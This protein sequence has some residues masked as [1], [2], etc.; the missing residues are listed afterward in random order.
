MHFSQSHKKVV[1]KI[2]KYIGAVSTKLYIKNPIVVAGT[3]YNCIYISN[4]YND[5]F[6]ELLPFCASI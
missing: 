6:N 2:G 4:K 3:S 1:L 5:F